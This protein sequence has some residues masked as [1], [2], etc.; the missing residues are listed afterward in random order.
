MHYKAKNKP[1]KRKKMHPVELILLIVAA[2]VFIGSAVYLANYFW[3]A[4]QVNQ[5]VA[6]LAQL[7]QKAPESTAGNGDESTPPLEMNGFKALHE[8]NPDI[9]GWITIEGTGVDYPVMQSSDNNFY[10]RRN[11]DKEYS[12]SGIP[13]LDYRN[14]L[15]TTQSNLIIYGHNMKSGVMFGDLAKYQ[16]QE[17]YTQHPVIAFNT[18]AQNNQYEIVA[19]FYALIAPEDPNNFAYYNFINAQTPEEF[20]NF[21]QQAMA[22]AFYNTGIT[23]QFGDELLTLSTCDNV[24]DEGRIVVVARK[25]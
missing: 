10:L 9:V 23:P 16:K 13:F 11:F 24:T 12:L 22:R 7:V 25:Q 17:F 3:Q 5:E 18:L 2:A 6:E 1:Q 15:S 20:D 4:R 8:K 14:D 21:L 19:V